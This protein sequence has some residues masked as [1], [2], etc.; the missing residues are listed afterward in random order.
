[1]QYLGNPGSAFAG[2]GD[3]VAVAINSFIS[4]DPILISPPLQFADLTGNGESADSE[5]R[6]V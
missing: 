2:L 4:Q 6:E 5:V 1:M 3:A